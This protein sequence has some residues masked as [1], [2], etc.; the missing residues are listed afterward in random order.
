VVVPVVV[1]VPVLVD[2]EV[3]V[4]LDVDVPVLVELL[5]PVDVPLVPVPEPQETVKL[6]DLSPAGMFSCACNA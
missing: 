4:L 1:D 5:V 6:L 3:P 2:V